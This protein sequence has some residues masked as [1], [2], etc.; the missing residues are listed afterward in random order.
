MTD[1]TQGIRHHLE[2]LANCSGREIFSEIKKES[3]TF[4]SLIDPHAVSKNELSSETRFFFAQIKSQIKSAESAAS[5][6][7]SI[8]SRIKSIMNKPSMKRINEMDEELRKH[9][10][11]RKAAQIK[12]DLSHLKNKSA[13]EIS[14]LIS[15]QQQ[16]LIKRIRLIQ[17]WREI[18]NI[19]MQILESV[20]DNLLQKLYVGAMTTEDRFL[21]ETVEKK[22]AAYH[23]SP[24]E[25][26]Q[27]KEKAKMLHAANIS[28]LRRELKDHLKNFV[29]FEK[30][31]KEK[32]AAF[33][34]LTQLIK[35]FRTELPEKHQ[36]KEIPAASISANRQPS[37]ANRSEHSQQQGKQVRMAYQDKK[38]G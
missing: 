19:E 12:R 2:I 8:Q 20:T 34:K 26:M 4:H 6:M 23:M 1:S 36:D 7:E 38:P 31:T 37:D 21:L 28:V 30:E 13:K 3:E 16:L 18:F 14:D 22:L 29:R 35:E 33:Q 25:A 10:D 17:I 27:W 15:F 32:Q 24:D 11:I 9:I 5:E